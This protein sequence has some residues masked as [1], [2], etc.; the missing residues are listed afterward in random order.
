MVERA[1]VAWVEKAGLATSDDVL[2]AQVPCGAKVCS[3]FYLP[4]IHRDR[5]L[6]QMVEM[7]AGFGF[8][9]NIHSTDMEVDRDNYEVASLTI[10]AHPKRGGPDAAKR[11]QMANNHVALLKIVAGLN[12]DLDSARNLR[13]LPR[14]TK[15]YFIDGITIGQSAS[16]FELLAPPGA[17]PP[18]P[19]DR[20]AGDT[21]CSCSPDVASGDARKTGYFARWQTFKLT[22]NWVCTAKTKPIE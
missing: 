11:L 12:V 1:F 20:V 6:V 18:S 13:G 16:S 15:F 10:V 7:A 22:C 19:P 4:E 9:A 5:V 14:G 8:G 21:G 2:V 3:Q 17:Q